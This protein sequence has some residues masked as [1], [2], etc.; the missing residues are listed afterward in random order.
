MVKKM[1]K[2]LYFKAKVFIFILSQKSRRKFKLDVA[3][4]TSASFLKFCPKT[5]AR[6]LILS[7]PNSLVFLKKILRLELTKV[8]VGC[9]YGAQRSWSNS[10]SKPE[11][12]NKNSK[13]HP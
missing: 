4:C 10:I 6:I 1:L 11:F 12:L 3:W 5:T 7:A 13:V 9:S 8:M 2:S